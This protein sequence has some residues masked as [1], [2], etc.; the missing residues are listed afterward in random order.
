MITKTTQ[1]ISDLTADL[2]KVRAALGD[3]QNRAKEA[4]PDL[5][6]LV[7]GE[8]EALHD[9][10]IET[11]NELHEAAR[12]L[13]ALTIPTRV[14]SATPD[15]PMVK[16]LERLIEPFRTDLKRLAITRE[17]QNVLIQDLAQAVSLLKPERHYGGG[18]KNMVAAV[19]TGN[20]AIYFKQD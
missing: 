9:T 19:R 8:L 20:A 13:M 11:R 6:D 12:T 5:I 14:D 15:V 3:L 2:Q 10:E 16:L 1:R 18:Y 17:M 7:R 4:H